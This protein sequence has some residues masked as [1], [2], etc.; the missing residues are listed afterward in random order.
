MAKSTLAPG[1]TRQPLRASE[2]WRHTEVDLGLRK[3]GAVAGYGK[4]DSFGDLASA[5]IGETVD[6]CNDWLAE[7]FKPRR[8]SLA[9]SYKLPNRDILPFPHGARKFGDVGTSRERALAASGQYHHPKRGIGLHFGQQRHQIVDQSVIERVE[10]F[11]PV[12][13]QQRDSIAPI[14]KNVV[15][16]EHFPG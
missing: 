2:R 11:R 6:G 7:G 14:E 5:A 16:H 3:H 12:E 15:G 8:Q 1:Q 4:M 9:A 13:R 10:F